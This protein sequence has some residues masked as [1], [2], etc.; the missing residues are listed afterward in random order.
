MKEKM[1]SKNILFLHK[2]FIQGGGIE[3]VHQNLALALI[4]KGMSASFYVNS[5]GPESSEGY[6]A[7]QKEFTAY[8]PVQSSSFFS[9]I[10]FLLHHIKTQK[11]DVIIAGKETANILAFICSIFSPSTSV[12]FTRHV[13]FDVSD[14]KLP[15][16]AIKMLYNLFVLTGQVV[17]VS[18]TL[19]QTIVQTVM[20]NKKRVHFVPNAVTSENMFALSN[21]N[22]DQRLDGDYFCAVGRLTEQKGFDLLIKAYAQ[23]KI[24][25]HNIPRLLIV[26]D[27][28]D[29]TELKAQVQHLGLQDCVEFTGFTTNPYYIIAQAKAFIL[30]SRHEGM[31]TV[32]IEAMALNR[33]VIAFNC[34]TGP[35]ELIENKVNGVLLPIQ[36]IEALAQA[37]ADYITVP[38]KHIAETVKMFDFGNVA[39]A[40][41]RHF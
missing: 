13:A 32:L 22:T 19:K 10:R 6:A 40:Y 24:I 15:P 39:N 3:K 12:I 27:G 20:W 38:D 28:E 17:A 23:A 33:P 9:K 14:Q 5:L 7:L 18:N 35:G 2:S 4:K 29:K 36:D 34:P 8:S 37:M 11:I 1:E 31:P 21:T 16:W 26:G 25:N 30:S 41:I